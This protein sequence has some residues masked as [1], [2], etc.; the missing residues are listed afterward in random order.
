MLIVW[1][2]LGCL[3]TLLALLAV[4]VDLTFSVQRRDGRQEAGATLR[5][6]F[7]LVRLRLGEPKAR[8]RATP[9]RPKARRD[10]GKRGGARRVLAMFRIEGFGW[11]LLRLAQDLLRHIRIQSLAMEVRLGLDDPADTGRLWALIGTLAAILP[12]PPVARVAVEPEFTC[13]ALE[14]DGEGRVRIIPIQL[15]FVMLVF[16]LSPGTLRALRTM[17][18]A[19]R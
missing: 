7:G 5:W 1:I 15:L 2:L 9:E 12:V 17:R 19:A 14:V 11:R 16:V 4:P 10:R 13:E 6:L 3:A 18:A 8:A